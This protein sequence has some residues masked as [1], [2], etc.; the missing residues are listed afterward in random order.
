MGQRRMHDA[1]ALITM[2]QGR[3]PLP[4]C[5]VFTTS[6]KAPNTGPQKKRPKTLLTEQAEVDGGAPYY[7]A[8]VVVQSLVTHYFL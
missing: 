7:R 6:A 4:F 5:Y 3:L 8:V 2:F 1:P